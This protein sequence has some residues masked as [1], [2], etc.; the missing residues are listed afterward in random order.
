MVLSGCTRGNAVPLSLGAGQ[1]SKGAALYQIKYM[2]K[3]CVETAASAT[4]LID[5]HK[6]NKQYASTADDAGT[7]EREA[8]YFCQRVI[9]HAAMELEAVQ[10]AGIVLGLH[11]SGSSDSMQY[12]S[13]WDILRLARI[14]EKGHVGDVD[15]SNEL[16]NDERCSCN[17]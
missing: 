6:H 2:A 15:F 16:I 7:I 13:G 12:F 14:A 3:E 17:Q 4:V 5:A 11:S 1:G 9:N 10:A 8:K